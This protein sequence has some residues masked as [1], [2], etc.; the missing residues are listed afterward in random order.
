[1]NQGFAIHINHSLRP[2]PDEFHCQEGLRDGVCVAL[3][4][5]ERRA[6]GLLVSVL[7]RICCL[8]HFEWTLYY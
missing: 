7:C 1:M 6:R 8:A 4:T 2:I 5:V 3:F